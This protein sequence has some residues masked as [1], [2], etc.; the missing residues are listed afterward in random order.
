MTHRP[1]APRPHQ[2]CERSGRKRGGRGFGKRN[3]LCYIMFCWVFPPEDNPP[4]IPRSAPPRRP[5]RRAAVA[6]L[7][8]SGR[9]G[10]VGDGVGDGRTTGDG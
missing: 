3:G 9:D 5:H 4:E 1:S 6:G 7:I 8:P 10:R 2:S